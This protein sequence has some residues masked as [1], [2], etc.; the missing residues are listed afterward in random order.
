MERHRKWQER[1][2]DSGLPLASDQAA[3]Y[4]ARR[5]AAQGTR[6]TDVEL[7]HF[8]SFVKAPDGEPPPAMPAENN[9]RLVVARHVRPE[10]LR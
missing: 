1:I 5:F 9:A 10:E 3:L 8:W 4:I 2:L 7:Y 6:P